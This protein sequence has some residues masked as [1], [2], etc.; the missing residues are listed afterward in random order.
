MA[1]L[2]GRP[3]AT[4]LVGIFAGLSGRSQADILSEFGGQGFGVFKPAL[5]ELAVSQIAPISAEMNKLLAQEDEI[6]AVLEKGAAQAQAIAAPIL[7]EVKKLVG[8]A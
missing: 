7:A 4:N 8:F 5:A 2:A 3:E 6:D 1:G